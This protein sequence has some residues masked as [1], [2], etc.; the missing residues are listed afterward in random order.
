M[1]SKSDCARWLTPPRPLTLLSTLLLAG[2]LVHSPC[3]RA[4]AIG[5]RIAPWESNPF[6]WQ[7]RGTPVLLL[8]GSEDDNLFQLPHLKPHLDEIRAAGGNYIRN[9]MSDRPD[10]GFEVYAYQRL[11][12]GRYDLDQWNEEYW[13]R[14]RNLLEWTRERDIIVQIEVWDRFDYARDNWKPHPYNPRNNINYTFESSGLEAAYPDH[15]GSNRQPFFFT[16]P[17]QRNNHVLLPYQQRFVDKM[18]SYSLEYGHV[19]YCID[20]ET[21]GAEEWGRYWADYI[22]GR[23]TERNVRVCITE[24]W[25]DWNLQSAQH[26]RTFDHPERY[27]FVDVSQNN[28]KRGQEHWDNFQWVR[29]YLS[30]RPRPINTVKTYGADG[31][32]FGHTNRDGIERFWRHLIGGAAS[33]RFHRPDSGLGLSPLAVAS[34]RAARKCE[35]FIPFWHLAPANDRLQ[36]RDDNEAY[37]AANDQGRI[38]VYITWGGSVSVALHE[39]APLQVRWLDLASGD[40]HGKPTRQEPAAGRLQLTAPRDGGWVALI[41]PVA[42]E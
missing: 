34:I 3:V 4:Q 16:T 33:A 6:Y 31:N 37:A 23:A 5:D 26:R 39:A 14:F 32:K 41:E 25:D 8:G 20:N 24:M 42:A 13:Q 22:R 28:H 1:F 30:D 29:Q 10:R 36:D 18:L 2:L 38:V 17:A 7:Y 35:A 40:W 12:D 11:D 15:P 21:S 9:T 27:D 19:L